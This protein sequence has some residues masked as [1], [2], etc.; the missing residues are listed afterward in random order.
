MLKDQQIE[1]A[2][3]TADFNLLRSLSSETNGNYFPIEQAEGLLTLLEG[4][5]P[6]GVIHS[7]E[8][9]QPVINIPW[10]FFLLLF[11]ITVEWSVRKY[12]G[13]Y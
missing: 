2:N 8:T 9:Y 11:L 3:L 10:L 12:S 13:S 4:D 7:H 6:T 5:E 1:F